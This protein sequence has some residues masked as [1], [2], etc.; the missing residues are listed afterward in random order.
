MVR[1]FDVSEGERERGRMIQGR[2]VIHIPID[3][4][5]TFTHFPSSAITDN[6][7]FKAL[8]HRRAKPTQVRSGKS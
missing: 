6:R 1:S 5:S 2:A 8:H 3:C 4:H 7:Q